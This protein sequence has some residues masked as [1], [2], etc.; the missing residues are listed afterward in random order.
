MSDDGGGGSTISADFGSNRQDVTGSITSQN[1]SQAQMQGWAVVIMERDNSTGRVS[2]ADAGGNFKFSKASLSAVQTAILLSPDYLIQSVLSVPSPTVNT[3]RQYFTLSKNS[4]PRIVQKGSIINF[5]SLD[6]ISV[7]SDLAS[8]AD[9]DG[10]PDGMA[11]LALTSENQVKGFN[12]ASVD[13]DRDGL[14]NDLDHDIDGDGLPNVVD[15]DD[16]GD[17]TF[18]TIDLD[19]NSNTIPDSQER[20]S[21]QHFAVGVEYV[22]VQNI[23]SSSGTSLRFVT[24][25]RDGLKAS[26][27]KIRGAKSLLENST[28]LKTDSTSGGTW[29]LSLADDGENDD[30]AASDSIYGRTVNLATGKSPRSNQMVFFQLTIGDGSEAFTAEFPYAFPPLTPAIPTTTYDSSTRTVS[31]AGDPLG[32]GVTGFVWIVTVKDSS[33][34]TVYA[35]PATVGATRTFVLPANIMESG[36]T[37]TYCATA[38]TLDKVSGYPAIV[39]RS[40]EATITP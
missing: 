35:S 26:S 2:E 18:D 7:Q 23:L 36:Q 11:S 33:G 38:Q 40:A 3:I 30:A 32:S 15:S 10:I 5:Q 25:V 27:L 24:K 29:D 34:N 19:A 14:V 20:L 9:G 13:T 1:G 31:L 8:D 17:G 4:L 39:V 12:L 22:A 28:V 6:S 16:N 21:D 37:Y